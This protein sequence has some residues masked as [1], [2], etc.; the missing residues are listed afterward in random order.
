MR[1]LCDTLE[2]EGYVTQG[3]SSG[4]A[5]PGGVASGR[6]RSAADGPDDAGNGRHQR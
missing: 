6:V 4:A 2:L 1:A 5:G 3:F